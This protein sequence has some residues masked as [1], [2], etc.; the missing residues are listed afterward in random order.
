VLADLVATGRVRKDP[1]VRRDR[2][3][4]FARVL[5]VSQDDALSVQVK[6]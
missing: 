4:L 3:P 5:R 1:T 2:A 6:V